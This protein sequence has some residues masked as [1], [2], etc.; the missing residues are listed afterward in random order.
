MV[1][2]IAL[3]GLL[4]AAGTAFAAAPSGYGTEGPYG[5][6]LHHQATSTFQRNWNASNES[7]YRG[8]ESA[9]WVRRHGSPF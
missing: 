5:R 4:T 6:R 9:R 2:T 3:I 1:R 8:A 7:K